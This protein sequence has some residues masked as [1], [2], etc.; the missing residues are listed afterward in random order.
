MDDGCLNADSIKEQKRLANDKR[1]ECG[2]LEVTVDPEELMIGHTSSHVQETLDARSLV[3]GSP[4]LS[5][6][7][8]GAAV[9]RDHLA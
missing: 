3:S 7:P 2:A 1:S 5:R 9:V 6:E 8:D 4:K